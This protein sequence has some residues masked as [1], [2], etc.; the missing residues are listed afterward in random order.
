[1]HPTLCTCVFTVYTTPRWVWHDYID[2]LRSKSNRLAA[3]LPTL[4]VNHA[5]YVMYV[6]YA[7][8]CPHLLPTLHIPRNRSCHTLTPAD[9]TLLSTSTR[10]CLL[11]CRTRTH[12][13]HTYSHRASSKQQAAETDI[14]TRT[15]QRAVGGGQTCMLS[16]ET[17]TA[18]QS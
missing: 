7:A 3:L 9:I 15:Q 13:Q 17:K 11:A 8:H 16:T 10:I 12:R 5:V 14:Q 18:Q 4:Y 2:Y 1:M 6:N